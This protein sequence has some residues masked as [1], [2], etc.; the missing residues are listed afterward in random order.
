[1]A[2]CDCWESMIDGTW[3]RPAT[4]MQMHAFM[5]SLQTELHLRRPVQTG[6]LL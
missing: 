3:E 6:S 4:L 2:G 1:M 5:V